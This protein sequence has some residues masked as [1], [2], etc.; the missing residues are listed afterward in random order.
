MKSRGGGLKFHEITTSE[1]SD[2]DFKPSIAAVRGGRTGGPLPA[3][4][5]GRPLR[6]HFPTHIQKSGKPVCNLRWAI[7]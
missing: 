1:F 5:A 3:A 7:R 6:G 2:P 4:V